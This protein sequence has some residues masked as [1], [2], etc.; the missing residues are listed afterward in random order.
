MV[1]D[2]RIWVFFGKRG[3]GPKIVR[4]RKCIH[5]TDATKLMGFELYPLGPKNDLDP[6]VPQMISEHFS[7]FNSS[8]F[9]ASVGSSIEKSRTI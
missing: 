4:V 1:R 6:M 7:S 3:I 8:L 5:F 9:E 2:L